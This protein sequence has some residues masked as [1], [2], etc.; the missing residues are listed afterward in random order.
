[1]LEKYYEEIRQNINVR[2]NLSLLRGQIKEKEARTRLLNLVGDGSFLLALLQHEEPKVRKNAA[3]LIGDLGL[4]EAVGSLFCAYKR[5]ATL[6]VRSSY[7][8]ALGRL[9]ASEYLV[10]LKGA[11]DALAAAEV[12]ENE[13]K[14]RAEELRELEKI[15]TGIEGIRRHTFTGFEKAQDILL[16]TNKEQR[17]V[18]MAEVAELSAEIQRSTALHP[19]GVLVH[20]K[21]VKPFTRLRTYREM[22]FPLKGRFP[23]DPG[24]AAAA[25][26]AL[27]LADLL[28]GCHKEDAP[29]YFRVELKSRMPLDAKS[30]Y[31]KR[32]AAEVERLSGRR[33]INSTQHYE[34]E[35][36]LVE[37]RDGGFVGFYKLFTI[38][39]KRFSYRK[40]AIATSIHPATAAMLVRLAK[41]YLKED[42]QILD[43]FCG[44]GTMLIERD[45]CVPAREKYGIDIFGDAIR[46]A[47][48]NTAAAGENINY[49]NRDY[50][51]FK[52]R[53]LF[54]EIITNMP[55]RS[56]AKSREDMDVFYSRF[57][58]KSAELLQNGGIIVMYANEEGLIKKQLRLRGDYR[59][60]Q[61]YCIREKDR[62]YL[63]IIQYGN[64]G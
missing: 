19:L 44:V 1:M 26:C 4:Q 38:P 48:E 3:L 50:F 6:F 53:Y 8:N 57:F 20:T 42:A 63:Y 24:Q 49:I 47:R 23:A 61:E 52:H 32:F 64:R 41:P 34:V 60:I 39:V 59:L 56:A 51:D 36:R 10:E 28:A 46:M 15:I 37:T 13:R 14:H 30:V 33:L 31:A 43:P 40:N 35:L 9:D 22:L 62:F 54:D 17:G 27:G 12:P 21:W 18:T 7:L 16:A 25:V 5:E 58:E 55:V 45:I 2:E 11:R 29:F